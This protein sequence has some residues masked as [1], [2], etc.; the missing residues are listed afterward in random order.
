MLRGPGCQ[1]GQTDRQTTSPPSLGGGGGSSWGG[2]RFRRG[3]SPQRRGCSQDPNP[4]SLIPS[5]LL[6]TARS[7]RGV[8][9]AAGLR[10]LRMRSAHGQGT[11]DRI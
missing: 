2:P 8:V 4:Q 11:T 5:P 6:G 7:R 1:D 10:T 3:R 9:L